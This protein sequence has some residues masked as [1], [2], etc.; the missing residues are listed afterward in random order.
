MTRGEGVDGR[1]DFLTLKRITGGR[2][3]GGGA[4]EKGG[5]AGLVSPR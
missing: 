2:E 1:Q 3:N 5:G 4:I